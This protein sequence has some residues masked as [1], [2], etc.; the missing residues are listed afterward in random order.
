MTIGKALTARSESEWIVD[1][2]ATSHMINKKRLFTEVEDLYPDETVTLGDGKT[3]E[4]KSIGNVEVEMP[5]L[6]GY[7]RRCFLQHVLYVPKLS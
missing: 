5:L 6:D 1:S 4:V 3:L 2:E 7:R